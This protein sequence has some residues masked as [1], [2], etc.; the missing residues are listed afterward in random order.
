MISR[1]IT[2]ISLRDLSIESASAPLR[3]SISS[4]TL[5]A[6]LNIDFKSL[7][8]MTSSSTAKILSFI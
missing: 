4:V 3:A 6:L 1:S 5:L 7:R 2:S 8:F